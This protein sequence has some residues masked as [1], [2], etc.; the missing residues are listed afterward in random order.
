MKNK[1]LLGL[2]L[3]ANCGY[4]INFP[5]NISFIDN[6]GK[7]IILEE[8]YDVDKAETIWQGETGEYVISYNPNWFKT[9]LKPEAQYFVFFHELGH[10]RLGHF[11]NWNYADL[12]QIQ[13]EADCYSIKLLSNSYGYD[14]KEYL[15]IE[16]FIENELNSVDRRNSLRDCL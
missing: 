7:P 8:T 9:K 16:D 3:A 10:I 2:V 15:V 11:K 6:N 14:D 12:E 5:V 4:G 1:T 13:K